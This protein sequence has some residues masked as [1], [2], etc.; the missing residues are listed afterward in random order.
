[1][2]NLIKA[3]GWASLMKEARE[4]GLSPEDVKSFLQMKQTNESVMMEGKKK[5]I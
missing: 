3:E 4:I 2:A 1:M 5:C